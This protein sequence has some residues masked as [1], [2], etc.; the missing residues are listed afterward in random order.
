ML[1]DIPFMVDWKNM[2]EHTQHMTDLNTT[3]KNEGRIDYDYQ[4]GQKELVWNNRTL[5]K[6]ESRY[7]KEHWTIMSVHTN[8]TI[9]VQ[10][11]GH[12]K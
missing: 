5:H 11:E 8:G 9:K 3:Q 1:F 12:Q 2:G 6:A 4:V 10:C 7:L